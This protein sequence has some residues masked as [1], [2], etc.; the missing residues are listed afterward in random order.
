MHTIMFK[1]SHIIWWMHACGM[2]CNGRMIGICLYD[3]ITTNH[4]C[5]VSVCVSMSARVMNRIKFIR[6]V[7]LLRSITTYRLLTSFRQ[8]SF[9]CLSSVWCERHNVLWIL[10]VMMMIMLFGMCVWEELRVL[11]RYRNVM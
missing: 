1:V 7:L 9:L 4:L 8:A 11:V 3:L 6:N 5:A 2:A 10:M